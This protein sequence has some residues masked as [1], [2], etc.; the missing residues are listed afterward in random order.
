MSLS[1]DVD[2][3]MIGAGA[4]G[5]TAARTALAFGASCMVLEARDR[6][7]GRVHTDASLGPH[8]DAGAAY[9][10]FCERNPW[11]RE[12]RRVG[13]ETRP[14]RGFMHFEPFIG[15][16][17][18][19]EEAVL[20]R[21][22]VREGFWT[23]LESIEDQ[24]LDQPIAEAALVLQDEGRDA[25]TDMSRLGLGEDPQH[26]SLRDYMALWDGPD[27][28]VPQGYGTLVR[29][30]AAGL[31]IRLDCPVSQINRTAAGFE[32]LTA[33]GTIKARAVVL[34]VS[35]GVLKAGHIGLPSGLSA[36]FIAGLDGLGMGALTKVALAFDGERFGIPQGADKIALDAPEG[37]MTFE[38]WPFD[39][40]LVLAVSGGQGGRRLI[41]Q[42]EAASVDEVARIFSTIIG[43]DCRPHLRGGRL[44]GWWGDPYSEGSYAYAKPD[45]HHARAKLLETGIEGFY[46]AGEATAGGR[47]GAC[48]TV[49]GA[50]YAGWD[51]VKK[52]LKALGHPLD[53]AAS[54]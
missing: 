51:A 46:Y 19:P 7:G 33:K 49:A 24:D 54:P 21:R 18:V 16:V 27:R 28:I 8:F 45:Q 31:P 40:N 12:A 23:H 4:A 41:A 6:V 29:A 26:V 10:H 14:W 38:L 11:V 13:I 15:G 20:R 37:S 17:R 52:A 32:V 48:M 36:D 42:G 3:V 9:I 43:R 1:T 44:S 22:R 25:I 2:L 53:R 35:V 50:S 34:T 5:I 30:A 47:F 39:Q